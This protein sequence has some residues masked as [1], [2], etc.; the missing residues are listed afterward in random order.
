ML[1]LELATATLLAKLRGTRPGKEA[2]RGEGEGVG[3]TPSALT[4]DL[5]SSLLAGDSL[6]SSLGVLEPSWPNLPSR[7]VC[8][9]VCGVSDLVLGEPGVLTPPTLSGAGPKGNPPPNRDCSRL[10]LQ[11]DNI[12]SLRDPNPDTD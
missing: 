3:D 8:R 6:P 1:V 7:G 10:F 2:G 5:E 4:G 9:S 12:S 11:E